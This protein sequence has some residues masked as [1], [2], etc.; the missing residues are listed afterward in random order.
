MRLSRLSMRDYGF[1]FRVSG[2]MTHMRWNGSTLAR[3]SGIDPVDA[4]E[5]YKKAPDWESGAQCQR[6]SFP[7]WGSS[8]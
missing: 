4:F 3:A 6:P 8:A 1:P 5:P 7:P 2:V